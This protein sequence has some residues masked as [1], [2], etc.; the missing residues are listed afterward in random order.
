MCQLHCVVEWLVGAYAGWILN[1]YLYGFT[2]SRSFNPTLAKP[3]D[4]LCYKKM[5]LHIQEFQSH[6][7]ID[8]LKFRRFCIG[9]LKFRAVALLLY[10]HIHSY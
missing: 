4:C 8:V 7:C 6:F 5:A 2:H 9:C 10:I 1:A 3:R